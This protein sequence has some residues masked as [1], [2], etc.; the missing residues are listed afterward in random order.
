MM[1]QQ[2][3]ETLRPLQRADVADELSAPHRAEAFAA[4]RALIDRVKAEV[5]I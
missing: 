3:G 2:V 1:G 4:C 5:P